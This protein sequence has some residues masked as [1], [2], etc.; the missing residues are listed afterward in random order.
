MNINLVGFTGS[1][2]KGSFNMLTLKAIKNLLSSEV[3]LDIIDLSD[4]PFFNEDIEDNIPESVKDFYDRLSKANGIVIA[5][6]E[7]NYSIPPVLKNALDWA[8]RSKDP[9][10]R[11]KPLAIISA[12]PSFLGGV[13]A[14]YH[15]RQVCVRLDLQPLNSP[16]VFINNVDKKFD[17]NGNLTDKDTEEILVSL[18]NTLIEKIRNEW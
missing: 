3:N 6:P 13:R 10:L 16:E 9:L 5:T 4:I 7:Y 2:R 8:S 18:I 12:S 17:E 14:Q 15:L 11:G 1:L